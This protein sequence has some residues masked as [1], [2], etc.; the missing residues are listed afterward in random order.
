MSTPNTQDGPLLDALLDS[1]RR[2]NLILINLLR[3]I[4]EAGMEARV[5]DGSPTVAQ[6]FIH[7]HYC[8]MLF[9]AEEAPE[10]AK[11]LPEGEWRAERNRDRIAAMLDESAGVLRDV[12][13]GRLRAGRGL[14]RRWKSVT[15]VFN[16]TPATA[17]QRLA[18]AE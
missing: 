13:V 6:M 7:M 1:W 3:A 15:V 16:A 10:L 5:V 17:T 4:P 18:P 12:V 14:D 11:P 8:R 9:A 2:N